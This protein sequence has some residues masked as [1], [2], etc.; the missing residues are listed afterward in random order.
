MRVFGVH[1][2]GF[3]AENGK[4]L[5]ITILFATIILLARWVLV[6]AVRLALRAHR[7]DRVVFWTRQ[8]SSV[9]AALSIVVSIISI[10]F[11]DPKRWATA[12]GLVSAGL[13]FALQKVITAL[14]GYVVIVRGKTFSV[15]DRITM[16]GGRVE[17][18]VRFVVPTHGVRILK[19]ALSR[20]ILR[21]FDEAGIGVASSTYDVVGFPPLR[22]DGEDL[23][24]LARAMRER[25]SET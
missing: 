21:A 7:N 23:A 24:K 2:L 6:G 12:A 17:L 15:G 20:A 22:I 18:T 8:G 5:L 10:W 19:D 11:D 25:P 9:L 16:G 1:L 13:A 4:K 14:A 3:D